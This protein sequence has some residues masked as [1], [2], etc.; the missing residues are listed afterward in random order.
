[1]SGP[2]RINIRAVDSG[3]TVRVWVL[4]L[5]TVF[6][7][8]CFGYSDITALKTRFFYGGMAIFLAALLLAAL[9]DREVPGF[10]SLLRCP[11]V[12]AL[13][14]FLLLSAVSA[15]ASPFGGDIWLGQ[16]RGGGLLALACYMALLTACALYGRAGRLEIYAAAVALLLMDMIALLQLLGLNPF[17]FYPQGWNFYDAGALYEGVF[18]S[19]VGNTNQLGAIF[20]LMLPALAAYMAVGQ[21]RARWLLLIPTALSLY[22]IC[23]AKMEGALCGA[24]LGLLLISP[25][26]LGRNKKQ[27][28]LLLAAIVLLLL[29]LLLSLY[30]WPGELP[31]TLDEARSLLH[32]QFDE[33]FGSY[34]LGIWSDTLHLI[35]DRP[36]LGWG[37]DCF[38]APYA[39][40]T[41]GAMHV[42]AAHNEY[43]HIAACCGVPAALAYMAALLLTLTLLLRRGKEHRRAYIYAA[44]LL[45][46]CIQAFFNFSAPLSAPLAWAVWGL[47]INL[48]ISRPKADPAAI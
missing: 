4:S 40:L 28:R 13:A 36:W 31:L 42:D 20:C 39:G 29:I 12:V 33:S 5:L 9:R 15:A 21:E 2:R 41:G 38:R 32:G 10:R 17:H 44:A 6:P 48:I 18:L 22:I 11:P 30:S 46:W 45:C 34:R 26:L 8:L 1:M 24:L 47:G 3:L 23:A 25:W 19:T 27:R 35:A 16:G 43:L 7:L 37:P 14:L